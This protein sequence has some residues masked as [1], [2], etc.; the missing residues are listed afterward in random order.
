ML[1]CVAVCC[2]RCV[3]GPS[4]ISA[5]GKRLAIARRPHGDRIP[6]VPTARNVRRLAERYKLLDIATFPRFND[7]LCDT[8]RLFSGVLFSVA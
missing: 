5:K 1:G 3:I 8:S 4:S 6:G 7:E 2:G